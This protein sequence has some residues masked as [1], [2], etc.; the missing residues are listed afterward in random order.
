MLLFWSLKEGEEEKAKSLIDKTD[1]FLAKAG[2]SFHAHLQD[3]KSRLS[4]Y[5]YTSFPLPAVPTSAIPSCGNFTSSSFYRALYSSDG[6]DDEGGDERDVSFS[7]EEG[8][9]NTRIPK[10]A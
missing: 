2:P 10:A 7:D 8:T 1:A 3:A 6:P 4:S 5:N 9:S